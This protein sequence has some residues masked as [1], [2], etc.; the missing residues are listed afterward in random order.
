M[1]LTGY[2]NRFAS[3]DNYDA[4]E[5]LASK[6]L[7]SAEL[8]ELQSIFSDRLQNIS[9]VLF[10]D[11][12]VV[13]GGSASINASTGA[14]TLSS[15]AVYV[16]GAVR[17][18]AASSLTIPTSGSIQLGVRLVESDV[19]EANDAA[20]RDP[21]VG[22]RNYQEGG[23]GRKK[24]TISWAW[25]GDGGTGNFF[26]VYDVVNAVLVDQTEPP[27]LDAAQQLIARYDRD[28]NGS[29]IV[30]GLELIALGKNTAGTNYLFNVGDGV[31]NVEGFK[32][33]KPQSTPQAFG[34]DPD[35]QSIANEPKTSAGA[36]AQTIT[37]NRKPFNDI[38]DVVITEEKTATLTHGAFTGALD[39]LPDSSVLS[40]QS[41]TQGATTYS[42]GTDFVLTSDQVDWSPGGAEPAPGSTYTVTYRCL[43]SVTPSNLDGDAGTFEITG[44]VAGTLVL[45]DYRWKLPRIDALA[46]DKDGFF[47][48]IKGVSSAFNPTAPIIPPSQLQLAL[49]QHDWLNA[50]TPTVENDGTRVMAMKEQRKLKDSVVELYKLVADERLQRDI[51]SREPTA[52]YGVFTDPLLPGNTLRDAGVTQDAVIVDGQLQLGITASTTYAAQNNDV[53]NILPSTEELLVTQTLQT[54]SMLINPYGNFDVIPARVTIVPNIDLWTTID[55]QTEETT[56]RIT[57]G[58]GNRSSTSTSEVTT[59]VEENES[60]VEFLRPRTVNFTVEGFG[61]SETLS[62]LEFDGI[63]VI[64]S[65]APQADA[66]GVVTGSFDIPSGIPAGIKLVDFVGAGGS[67]G[68]AEYTGQGT[69]VVRRWNR[70]R[71]ISTNRWWGGIDPLAQSF[72]LGT[73]RQISGIDLKF[74]TKGSDDNP[75]YV[76]IRESDNGFP[77]DQILA[78]AVINGSDIATGASTFVRADF[79]TPVYLDENTEYF[80][81]ILSNDPSHALRVAELGQ[82]DSTNQQW[83]TAQP[84]TVGVLLSSSNATTW[85]AHQ[86]KDLTFRLVGSSFSSTSQT[87]NLGTLTVSSMSDLQVLAPIDLPTNAASILFRYTRSTGEIFELTPGQSLQFETSISDTLSVQVVLTGTSTVSPIVYPGVQTVTGTLDASAFYQGRQ[88]TVGSS[89]TTLR[90]IYD[91][92]IPGSSTITPTYDNN[93]FQTLSLNSA[94]QIGDGFSEYV[95]E[96]TGIVGLSATKIKLSLTGGPEARPKIRNLRA[97]MV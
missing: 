61:S 7:Q 83:V 12:G 2:Y 44:A 47:H 84:Y 49:I 72:S 86:E 20:L 52:K 95:Y 14:V 23:A 16:R 91:A 78:D 4:V 96:A 67:F 82:F 87:F 43:V 45:T 31:A 92:I 32:I 22:T 55:E 56:R 75:V 11:G 68:A 5:F 15:G 93:G 27:S 51:S 85:T 19:T 77:T 73:G 64:P 9:D 10:K 88:F 89:G 42:E 59:L 3:S 79:G 30:R 90:V 66:S 29:Y 36:T 81:V 50:T 71:T 60:S 38:Q 33:T 37:V 34:I 54:G 18:I 62:E 46:L 24:R 65:P 8:N 53:P 40:L 35:L 97:V 69:L 76:Q 17:E 48:R 63:D 1:T 6:G 13:R 94:N 39:V 26:S 41:V 28:S 70:V 80:I 25:S 57:R 74:A 21:A 58:S